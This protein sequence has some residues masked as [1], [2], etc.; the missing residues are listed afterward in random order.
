MVKLIEVTIEETKRECL[1]LYEKVKDQV[2]PKSTI[3]IFGVNDTGIILWDQ[4]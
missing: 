3:L 4:R 2:H 1:S